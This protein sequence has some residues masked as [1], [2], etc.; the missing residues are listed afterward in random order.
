M[1]FILYSSF[2]ILLLFSHVYTWS[3]LITVTGI[4]LVVLF[5]LNCYCSRRKVIL[6]SLVVI[7]SVVIDVVRMEMTGSSGG[8]ERDMQVAGLGIGFTQ[9]AVRWT[10]LI[11][12]VQILFGNIFSNFLMLGLGLYWVVQSKSYHLPEIFIIVFLSIGIIPLFFGS[13]LVQSRIIYD[14]PFQIPAAMGLA[15]IL[16]QNANGNIVLFAI[17]IWLVAISIRDVSNFYFVMPS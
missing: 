6:L 11:H 15:R 12:T 9:F 8:I 17:C 10:T 16:K 4:L 13:S 3:I 7:S 2:L 1:N 14:I 5:K